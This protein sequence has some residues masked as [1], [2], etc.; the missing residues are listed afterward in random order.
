MDATGRSEALT[1]IDYRGVIRALDE[2]LAF[3]ERHSGSLSVMELRT[4]SILGAIRS[5]LQERLHP[6]L[7]LRM[8][9]SG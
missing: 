8:E 1:E 4:K 7:P 3:Y 6:D 9:K 2:A 5:E